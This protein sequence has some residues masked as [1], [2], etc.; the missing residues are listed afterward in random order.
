MN[1]IHILSIFIYSECIIKLEY[2]H[3]YH[4]II[5]IKRHVDACE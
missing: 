2:M 4:Q 5:L 3:F 1:Y